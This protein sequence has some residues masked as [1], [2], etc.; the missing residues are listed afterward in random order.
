MA[1]SVWSPSGQR[2]AGAAIRATRSR[3]GAGAGSQ[4]TGRD[5]GSHTNG[6]VI[7]TRHA[8]GAGLSGAITSRLSRSHAGTP[9]T[10]TNSDRRTQGGRATVGRAPR[11][12]GHPSARLGAPNPGRG[13]GEQEGEAGSRSWSPDV[14]PLPSGGLPM[15]HAV[16]DRTWFAAVQERSG[17]PTAVLDAQARWRSITSC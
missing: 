12:R 10:G 11:L 3:P 4:R 8:S 2:A 1:D 5:A 17:S 6:P 13:C 16:T 15:D 14:T 7:P 9:N